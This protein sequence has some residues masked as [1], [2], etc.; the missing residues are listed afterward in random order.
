MYKTNNNQL[1]WQVMLTKFLDPKNDVAFKKIFGSEKNKDI[2]ICFLN[3][4]LEFKGKKPIIEVTFLK[5]VQE[6]EIAAK[7][8]SIV[9][10]M[11]S[12]EIGNSYIVEMQVAK[13]KGFIKR[14]QFYAAKAYSSQ[15]NI[16][17][18][19]STL[20]EIIFLAIADFIMFPEKINYKSDHIILDRDSFEHDL[21]DFSF[22]FLELEKFNKPKEQLI[23]MIEK[24]CYFFKHAAK[25]NEKDL[26]KIIGH[27]LIIK[28][29]YEEL[30]RFNWQEE[31]LNAYN[32]VIK[33]EMDYNAAME[34]KYDEGVA[35]G[36]I[37]VK[38]E[39][40][41][42]MLAEE[43]DVNLIAKLTGLT[44]SEINN[45]KKQLIVI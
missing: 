34:Q 2:L 13:E 43:L 22:T 3:D 38:K 9:D 12:D 31:E 1:E 11:C 36:R 8:T 41:L 44:I 39:I 7:K 18:K 29:A 19:Y 45:F 37:E 24:W 14:A 6:P 20:K 40:I 21:K 17:G 4:I 5:T 33:K 23:T 30:N 27:D 35:T 15:L 25:T 10:I 32:A 42:D 26:N 28:K 16:K